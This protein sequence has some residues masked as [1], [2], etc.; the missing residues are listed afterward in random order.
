MQKSLMFSGH[1]RLRFPCN[2]A[3]TVCDTVEAANAKGVEAPQQSLKKKTSSEKALGTVS[4]PDS[5]VEAVFGETS[6]STYNQTV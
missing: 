1:S 6:S 5:R 2:V 3:Y 4:F